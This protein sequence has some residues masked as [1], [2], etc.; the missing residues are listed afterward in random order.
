[1]FPGHRLNFPLL[2]QA[3]RHNLRIIKERLH[4]GFRAALGGLGGF[5]QR[6]VDAFWTEDAERASHGAQS[7]QPAAALQ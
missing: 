2:C 6:V 1:M 5:W 3:E 4:V 7:L